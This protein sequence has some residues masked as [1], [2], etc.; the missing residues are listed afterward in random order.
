MAKPNF[1]LMSGEDHF[2]LQEEVKRW[3]NAFV[4]KFGDSDLEELDGEL[5]DPETLS[6]TL[7]ATPFLSEKRLV[8]LK[9][10]L[11]SKKAEEANALLPTLEQLPDTTFLLMTEAE[12]DKRTSI[13]KAV[14]QMATQRLFIK[15]KGAQLSTWVVRRMEA[16]GAKIDTTTASY[17]VNWV[18]DDLSALMNEVQKLAL[19]AQGQ[20]VTV[21]M[22]DLLV[23]NQVEQSIFNLTDQLSKK[24]YAAVLATIDSLQKQGE[25]AAFLFAMITRQF[26]LLLEMKALSEEG[27]DQTQIARTMGVH[28]FVVQNTLRFSKNFTHGELRESLEQLLHLDERLKTGRIPLKPRDEDQFLLALEKILLHS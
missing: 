20:A 22:I 21:P 14:T 7:R 13:F 2:S 23:S 12:P 8:V 17:L 4:E 28:P 25:E 6:R 19:Y 18:G 27:K 1:Y 26:R 15:P 11:T 16:L 3:K 9:N 24:D 10:F 5:V